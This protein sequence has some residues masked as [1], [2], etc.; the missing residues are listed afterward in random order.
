MLRERY[1]AAPTFVE[2]VNMATKNQEI[3]RAIHHLARVPEGLAARAAAVGGHWHLLVLAEDWCGDAFNTVPVIA[4]LVEGA[5]N[6]DLRILAR[7]ENLDLME[8][9]LSPTGGRAIPVVMILDEEFAERAW[10]GSRPRPL[11]EWFLTEGRVL[12]PAERYPR[13]RQWYARD[14]GATTL[15]EVVALLER[16]AV[17]RAAAVGADRG[18]GR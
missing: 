12:V 4:K 3:W 7:D 5:T 6:L 14:H 17:E 10:W 18:V 11:Q 9:H 1:L 8:A 15:A 13:I 2:Y 16:A